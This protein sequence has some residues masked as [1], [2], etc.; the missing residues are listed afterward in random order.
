MAFTILPPSYEEEESLSYIGDS[1]EP[2]SDVDMQDTSR[3]SKR[4][5]LSKKSVVT[6]GE[7]VTDDPQ[8]MRSAKRI[9]ATQPFP[10]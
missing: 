1:S 5:K 6:P 2:D 4:P 9:V 10:S 3:A 8:W 7:L